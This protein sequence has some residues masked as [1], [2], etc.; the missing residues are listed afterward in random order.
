MARDDDSQCYGVIAALI[1][2]MFLPMLLNMVT[3]ALEGFP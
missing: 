2:L 3:S 1:L